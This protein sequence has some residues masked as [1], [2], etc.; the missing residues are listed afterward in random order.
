MPATHTRERWVVLLS[1]GSPL[2]RTHPMTRHKQEEVSVQG[3]W[4]QEAGVAQAVGVTQGSAR[5]LTSPIVRRTHTVPIRGLSLA[6]LCRVE[7]VHRLSNKRV[8]SFLSAQ[9]SP[10]W[11]SDDYTVPSYC[12]LGPQPRQHSDLLNLGHFLL[13]GLLLLTVSHGPSSL[14]PRSHN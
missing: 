2:A 13:L 3:R 12:P 5:R 6:C 14:S 7:G 4:H 1:P 8:G 9:Y 10:I 11:V